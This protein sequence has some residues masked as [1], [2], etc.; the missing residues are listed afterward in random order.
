MWS[1]L[2]LLVYLK[3]ARCLL[4]GG[5]SLGMMEEREGAAASGGDLGREGAR[6]QEMQETLQEAAGRRLTYFL[7][8]VCSQRY[9]ESLS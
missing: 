5:D 1:L 6:P 8:R 2:H 4:E 7:S 9:C 3:Q